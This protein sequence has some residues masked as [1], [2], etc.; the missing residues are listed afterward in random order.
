[1]DG[2]VFPTEDEAMTYAYYRKVK[3]GTVPKAAPTF[4]G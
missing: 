1:V 2:A 3:K 4:R